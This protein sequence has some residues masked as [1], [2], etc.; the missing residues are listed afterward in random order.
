MKL[1][2]NLAPWIRYGHPESFHRALDEISLT[3][4][5]GVDL[6][7]PFVAETYARRPGATTDAVS[8]M[9]RRSYAWVAETYVRRPG[10]L[11]SLLALHGLELA[12]WY[13]WLSYLP[14]CRDQE[15]ELIRCVIEAAVEAGSK[16]LLI[17]GGPRPPAGA[18]EADYQRVAEFANQIGAWAGEAGLRCCWHQH[19]GTMFEW[20]EPFDHLMAL[21]DPA[22]VKFCPDTAQL[23]MGDFDV[24][25]TFRKYAPRI[26]HVH[27]KD[28]DVNH[29]WEVT[30]RHSGPKTWGDTGGYRVDSRWRMVELGRGLIDFPAILA[31]L[32]EVGY[33]GW[34]VDDFDYSAYATQEA[35]ITCLRYLR[36]GLGLVGRR[37]NEGWAG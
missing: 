8:A 27:F 18:G 16:V 10:E 9:A 35:S 7:G 19:W 12:S 30:G 23:S 28:L 24:R 20:A 33:D 15:V 5:D 26:G 37:G 1:G 29:N 25:G 36:E 22:L 2:Y 34:I 11:R 14:E 21:T 32:R 13:C 3:G 17:D 4:W 6:A 31:I